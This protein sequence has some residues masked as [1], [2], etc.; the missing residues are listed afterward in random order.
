[1]KSLVEKGQEIIDVCRPEDVVQISERLR[2][3]KERW[4][5]TKDRAQKRKV[6]MS[7]K[8]LG[9]LLKLYSYKIIDVVV[10]LDSVHLISEKLKK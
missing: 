2:K 5:D 3:L 6:R 7:F 9:I 4:A 8:H 10:R 1:M